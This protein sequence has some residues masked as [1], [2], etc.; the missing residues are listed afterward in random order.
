[1]ARIVLASYMI[2]YPLG[3]MMSWVLQY[4]SGFVALGHEVWFVEQASGHGECYDPLRNVTGDDCSHGI[5]AVSEALES[6]GMADRWCFRD[7]NGDYHGASR[8]RIAEA[9]RTADVFFDMGS[10]GAWLEQASGAGCRVWIDGEP[11][12]TQMRMQM[13]VDKGG[14]PLPY[15]RWYTT[16]R[17]IPAGTANVPNGNRAWHPIFHPVD[18]ERVTRSPLP[19]H[20]DAAFTTVMNWQSSKPLR[21]EGRVYGYK[22][23]EF[24]KFESLPRRV[25]VPLELAAAKAPS[26]RLRQQG[27]RVT[28][29][30]QQ[31][32][33]L[34]SFFDYVRASRGEFSVCKNGFVATNSGWFSD[35]SAV[36][37]ASGR[38]VVQQETGFSAHLPCGEGLFAVRDVDDAAA[39]I[40]AIQTDPERHARAARE[41]A[42]EHLD[43][44]KVLGKV[45][46][47]IGA[48]GR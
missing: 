25:S 45:L 42:C 10:H 38:P 46:E 9:L 40:E 35:R 23:M 1:M 6:L 36:Y 48:D 43:A 32:V 30:R 19:T 11:G 20:P 24:E 8:S 5:K 28:L 18:V 47:E 15:D 2:R 17:N 29:G 21:F 33:S 34:A 44:K 39:A 12:F 14:E 4:L 16:G 31:T 37:L 13:R 41:I 26:S 3:G 27:W 7:V 22:D